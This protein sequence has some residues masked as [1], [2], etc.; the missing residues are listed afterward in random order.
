[1]WP[2]TL[3]NKA[4]RRLQLA[5]EKGNSWAI[6]FR[7]LAARSEPSAAALRI[8]LHADG[9]STRLTILKSRGGSPAVL[10][11]VV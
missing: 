6:A 1:L 7:P 11:N 2:E 9:G 5:A 10:Y 4:G 8:E 3:D